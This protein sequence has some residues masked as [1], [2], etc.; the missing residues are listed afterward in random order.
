MF[1]AKGTLFKPSWKL[2]TSNKIFWNINALIVA[3]HKIKW[4]LQKSQCSINT[5][6]L[7]HLCSLE[8]KLREKQTPKIQDYVRPAINVIIRTT[9][10]DTYTGK[11]LFYVC[12]LWVR[13]WIF[14]RII[15]APWSPQAI[16][17]LL[18]VPGTFSHTPPL[19]SSSSPC[20]RCRIEVRIEAFFSWPCKHTS[21]DPGINDMLRQLTSTIY[22]HML[23]TKVF[24]WDC[25]KDDKK[26][27]NKL[28]PIFDNLN[29]T[30]SDRHEQLAK[31]EEENESAII[32]F[33][34]CNLI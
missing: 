4:L 17:I 16:L 1:V 26:V 25:L 10:G 2:N 6:L 15:I 7:R 21:P 28:R 34:K 13:K 3:K 23:Q 18:A 12:Y 14:C 24:F 27:Q 8:I 30:E 32:F 5:F 22:L 19:A 31:T 29:Y 20:H 11:P 33:V 9:D